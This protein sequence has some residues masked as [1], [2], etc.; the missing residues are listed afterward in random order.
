MGMFLLADMYCYV[1]LLCH[2]FEVGDRV[3]VR[4]GDEEWKHGAVTDA[5]PGSIQVAGDFPR[6]ID[7]WDADCEWE[8]IEKVRA[9]MVIIHFF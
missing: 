3:R 1:M 5:T 9:E 7:G 8:F 6:K 4:D 2:N